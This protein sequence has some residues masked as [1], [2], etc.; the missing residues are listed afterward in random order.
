MD[1]PVTFYAIAA[2]IAAYRYSAIFASKNKDL[3]KAYGYG[4][5]LPQIIPICPFENP[6]GFFYNRSLIFNVL[7]FV[8]YKI[9]YHGIKVLISKW[10]LHC[11]GFLKLSFIHFRWSAMGIP[12][13]L[14][15]L[16]IYSI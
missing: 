10:Q 8:K 4:H 5:F 6:Q 13:H 14:G 2:N 1:V 15:V 9:T 16:F 12:I 7:Y 11:A 3:K